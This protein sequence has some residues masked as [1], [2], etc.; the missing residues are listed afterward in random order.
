M[1]TMVRV[2]G[3]TVLLSLFFFAACD[4]GTKKI[5]PKD[6]EAGADTD[7]LLT[8]E[9]GL[10]SDEDSVILPDEEEDGEPHD[11]D[12][13]GD[14][15]QLGKDD[16]GPKD[17]AVVTDDDSGTPDEDIVPP[18]C[19]NGW[20]D[21]GEECDG[22]LK[23]CVEI[24]PNLYYAGKAKCLDNCLGW[25]TVTCDAYA[26]ECGNGTVEYPE[27]CDTT[28]LTNCVEIDPEKYKAGKAYCLE[29]CSGYDT[30]T[31]EEITEDDDIVPDTTDVQPDPDIQP[32]PDVQPDPD[33]QP[34]PDVQP[35]QDIALPCGAVQ[36]NGS[37]GYIEVAHKAVLNL[38][39]DWTIEAWVKQNSIPESTPIIRKGNAS[40]AYP[41]Y[42]L[43]GTSYYFISNYPPYGGYYYDTAG[44]GSSVDATHTPS[45]GEWYHIALVKS[46]TTIAIFINGE[47]SGSSQASGNPIVTSSVPLYFGARF[48]S[49]TSG[50]FDG[51]IDEIRI[52]GVARYASAFT[53]VKRLSNDADTIGLWHFEEGAGTTAYDQSPN[54]LNGTVIGGVTWVND[55][56]ANDTPVEPDDDVM[57]D[58]DVDTDTVTP[59]VD[60][61][62]SA[63]TSLSGASRMRGNFFSCTTDRTLTEIEMYLDYSGTATVYFDVYSSATLDGTYYPVQSISQSISMSGPGFYSSGAIA[64]PLTA[65]TYYY[66]G[67]RWGSS[68]TVGYYNA[69][70]SVPPTTVFGSWEAGMLLDDVTAPSSFL[71]ND[72]YSDRYAYYQRL[73]T[74]P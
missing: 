63:E 40:T 3:V 9:D 64:I 27:V 16:S 51:L 61:V 59:V 42:Y 74:T 8:D 67:A 73:T 52:S 21:E 35:D 69:Y 70:L 7:A 57:P 1:I 34:D 45:T 53:P 18:T 44:G 43:Y 71:Y 46:G 26:H 36:L 39:G 62:G 29:D 12:G 25:D 28:G 41:S 10:W 58:V 68:Y 20:V 48:A 19:G 6:D 60:T 50:Y 31:C 13:L 55:C 37:D 33:I 24:D 72:V 2:T 23:D 32:D 11:G 49:D 38:T 56:A 30:A 54:L 17:D 47:Q 66:I 5:V 4:S 15:D 65:G 22:G 14:G